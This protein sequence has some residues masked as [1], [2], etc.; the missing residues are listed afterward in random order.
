M[1]AMFA[2]MAVMAVAVVMAATTPS[3]R[4]HRLAIREAINTAL[5]EEPSLLERSLGFT[6]LGGRLVESQ[7]VFRDYIVVTVTVYGD[8]VVSIGVFGKVLL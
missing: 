6:G 2:V 8:Q 3:E 4:Q 1:K 7:V 5:R